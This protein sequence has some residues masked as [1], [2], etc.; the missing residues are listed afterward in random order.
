MHCYRIVYRDQIVFT[1]KP[2]A[3]RGAAITAAGHMV[4]RVNA[5]CVDNGLGRRYVSFDV[6][7]A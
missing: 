6:V 2:Y 7:G 1:S 5:A 3:N 4:L